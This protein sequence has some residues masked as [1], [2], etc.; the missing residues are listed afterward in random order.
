[1]RVNPSDRC[2][3]KDPATLARLSQITDEDGETRRGLTRAVGCT[4]TDMEDVSL[5]ARDFNALGGHREDEGEG[6]RARAPTLL[7]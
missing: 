1:M 3:E 7:L 2:S 5:F 4:G 6:E